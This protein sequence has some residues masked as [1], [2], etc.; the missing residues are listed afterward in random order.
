MVFR[1]HSSN[2]VNRESIVK[3]RL[4]VVVQRNS[5]D[6]KASYSLIL[7]I[8]FFLNINFFKLQIKNKKNLEST[9][10][11]WVGRVTGNTTFFLFGLN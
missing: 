6:K 2:A 11:I 9:K 1:L 5:L 7:S 8:L 3:Y 10:K 4:P